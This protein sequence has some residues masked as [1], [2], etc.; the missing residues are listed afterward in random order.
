MSR[1]FFRVVQLVLHFCGRN[2][3]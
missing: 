2:G 3:S 1:V